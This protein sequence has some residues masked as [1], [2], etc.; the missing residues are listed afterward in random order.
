MDWTP[1]QPAR[2]LVVDDHP[3]YRAAMRE[4]V[5]ATP[6]LH[7]AGEADSGEAAVEAVERLAVRL[8]IMDKRMPG[9]GG[10]AA[11]QIIT[12]RHRNVVVIVCSV[13]DSNFDRA[14][15]YG[16]KAVIHKQD[17]SPARLQE[18]LASLT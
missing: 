15:S 16:A 3:G 4:V 17:L 10:L 12:E 7:V 2:V 14:R 6:G 9:M 8:V 18:V 5:Q 13:E 11:C 1:H